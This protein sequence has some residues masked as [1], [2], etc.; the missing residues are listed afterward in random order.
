MKLT[1]VYKNFYKII[2]FLKTYPYRQTGRAIKFLPQVLSRLEK[3]IIL[4]LFIFTVGLIIYIGYLTWINHTQA[5]ADFGGEFREGIVGER[6]DID[7]HLSRL[8][9]AGL[10]KMDNNKNIV[11]DIAKD[12]EIKEN[13]KVYEFHLR[14]NFNSEDLAR[15]IINQNL[16]QDINIS[17]PEPQIITFTFKQPFSPFLYASTEPIFK[18]GPYRIS[19]E[20]KNE[21]TL[22]ARDDYYSGRPYID[23]II[24]RYFSSD[25]ELLKSVR[26]GD[27]SGFTL[28]KENSQNN[29]R[30]FE[31]GL[32][33][34][35]IL[36]FNLSRKDLQDINIRKALKENSAPAKELNLRLVTSDNPKNQA[37]AN[38]IQKKWSQNKVQIT[39]DIKD[40][41][42]LQKTTIP[43]RDYDL[44][45]YSLDYGEDPDPYPFWHSSQIK[46]DGK[47]LANF[48][49]SKA[50]KLLEEARQEFDFSKREEK[51]Q[52]F[53]KIIDAE[54]PMFVVE[55]QT[56]H[57][58]VSEKIKGIEKIVGSCEADRF[59]NVAAWYLETKRVKKSNG[60][61]N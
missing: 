26:R 42:T 52:E 12:W 49:N 61:D 58:Y 23:K 2:R 32:P 27:L 54:I 13:G 25:E 59:L 48:K 15:E 56:L 6:K 38:E 4:C 8:I 5:V 21:I 36:F 31:I 57:Y 29:F 19:D 22:I 55:H 9:Y 51:Y 40:N 30:E 50:D 47:N 34:Y 45:L 43:Q 24:I 46:E 53:Q 20:G 11:G 44:L 17:T 37:I 35:L 33:R 60:G 41:I 28:F 7:K 18:Y 39:L 10:T 3:I 1:V 16:W 14:P